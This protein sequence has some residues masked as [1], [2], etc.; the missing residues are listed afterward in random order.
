MSVRI[1]KMN[2]AMVQM[3]QALVDFGIVRTDR[4]DPT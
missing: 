4:A 1:L 3:A 2:F